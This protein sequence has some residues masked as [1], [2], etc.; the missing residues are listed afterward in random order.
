MISQSHITDIVERRRTFLDERE[1]GDI[2]ASIVVHN[3]RLYIA[4]KM[5]HLFRVTKEEGYLNSLMKI[6][7]IPLNLLRDY[8]TPIGDQEG[9]DRNRASVVPM[10][11]VFAFLWLDG[12]M[13]TP[14]DKTAFLIGL[15]CMVPGAF[16]GVVIKM[17]TKVT[18]APPLFL[19]ISA[20]F[21]FVMAIWW[22][23]F[24]SN[25]IMDLLQLFGF[26]T[27]LPE[28]LLALTI[29]AWGNCLGDMTADV[30]MT[31]R[32]FG[33]M[34][35]TGCVAGP[36]FNVLIGLGLSM[37]LTILQ[38]S[39]PLHSKVNFSLYDPSDPTVFN[40]VSILPLTLMVGQLASL[41]LLLVNGIRNDFHISFNASLASTG[42]Y[43][44]F[45]VGLVAYSIIEHIQP[46]SG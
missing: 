27:S 38:S 5:R 40:K 28:A 22:I 39:D 7:S 45:I 31:K 12:D 17:K 21:C 6:I 11:I 29:I 13:Q 33:E 23:Q 41:T 46:P 15:L 36:I 20:F 2:D 19:T 32:G 9:W 44:V 8:T 34:A 1:K 18:Q 16:L 10:T 14:G 3:D 4:N 26:I 42:M 30:A 37:T 25:C 35:I 24:T 43:F